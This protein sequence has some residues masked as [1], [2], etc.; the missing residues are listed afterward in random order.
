MSV[1][2]VI[3]DSLS[4]TVIAVSYVISW[5]IKPRYNGTWRYLNCNEVIP[6]LF[7]IYHD[8]YAVVA[9]EKFHSDM[10]AKNWRTSEHYFLLIMNCQCELFRKMSPEGPLIVGISPGIPL[11]AQWSYKHWQ[12]KL[13]HW[14]L[15]DLRHSYK[16]HFDP[17][18][19]KLF[20]GKINQYLHFV[21]FFHIDVTQ[22]VEI[23][24]QIRQ[25]PTYSTK[26]ISWLLMSWRR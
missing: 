14:S 18:S 1:V 25:E 3:S 26:P 15:R 22:V 2:I 10:T 16:C 13:T 5:K 9:C 20:R 8:S 24:P 23:L 7:C 19:A 12:W 4:A 6:L 11:Q 17:L 21:S